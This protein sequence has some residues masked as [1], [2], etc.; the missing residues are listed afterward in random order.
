MSDD[1][2]E[3]IETA[4]YKALEGKMSSSSSPTKKS[5]SRASKND[6]DNLLFTSELFSISKEEDTFIPEDYLQDL[7]DSMMRFEEGL[8]KVDE[9]RKEFMHMKKKR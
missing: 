1:L 4:I 9:H 7:I 2:R 5:G 8:K 3:I 6:Y